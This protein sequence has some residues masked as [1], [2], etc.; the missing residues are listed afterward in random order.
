[1]NPPPLKAL[2]YFCI[3]AGHQNF[4]RAA[5]ELSVTPG[6]VSQ[7]I[8]S[9]EQWMGLQ[10]FARNARQ[11]HLTEAGGIFYRRVYPLLSEVLDISQSMQRVNRSGGVRIT[12]P[13]SF[14]MISFGPALADFR[15]CNPGIELQ[16]HA[17]SMLSPLDGS[18]HDLAI[19]F[20]P[21]Q[22][23]RLDCTC[24]ARLEVVVACSPD[25]LRRHPSLRSGNLDGCTLIHD[26]LHQDWQRMFRC[27]G[28][29][30]TPVDNLYFDQAIL[31]HQAAE[32]GLGLLLTDRM[33][34]GPALER[35]A[36]V[37]PVAVALPARRH[38]FLAHRRDANLGPEAIALKRWILA[39]F[40][41]DPA[42][43]G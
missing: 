36:L 15:R 37:M 26:H 24:L 25:Y 12:L 18:D 30:G 40:A 17:S 13:P 27:A 22:D 4:K 29:R 19:R 38:L 23:R 5:E 42:G 31:S 20:L 14:A 10:L 32:G 41:A 16:V 1:M 9:L 6:A 28:L 33:L 34:A 7:Q 21:G 2:H 3:A 43:G 35:G 8:R 39:H 11:V